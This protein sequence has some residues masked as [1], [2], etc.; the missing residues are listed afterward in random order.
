MELPFTKMQGCGNDYIYINCFDLKINSPESLSVLL[1]DRHYGIGGDGVVLILPSD[2]ADARMRMFNL[3]GSEGKMCGNAIR[4]IA[5]Y[6]YDNNIVR[7]LDM[8]IETLSGIRRLNLYTRNSFVST[9]RVD[10][11]RAELHPSQIPVRLPGDCVV[12][13]PVTIGGKTMEIT[14]VSM[15][16]PHCVVFCEDVARLRLAETGPLLENDKLFPD[17]VNAEFVELMGRNYL[18]MRVWERGSGETMSCGTGACAAAVAAVLNGYCD[19]DS[20]IRVVLPG[21]ELTVR[22]T[23]D[24]V[25]MTGDCKKV[26]DGIVEG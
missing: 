12:A 22:Y 9:V 8:T 15:G 18:K 10:M 19:K 3:D 17:R 25:F 6:L 5:K 13:R 20:D 21:G 11:G 4:C 16:N 24:A 23:E 1:A 2:T 7:K 14:C 26:F